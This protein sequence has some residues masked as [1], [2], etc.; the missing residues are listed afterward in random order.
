MPTVFPLTGTLALHGKNLA[1]EVVAL[2]T[3]T[4]LV[5][6]GQ[7]PTRG[8][9]LILQGHAPELSGIDKVL[10]SHDQLFLT[11]KSPGVSLEHFRDPSEDTLAVAGQAPSLLHTSLR[12]PAEV[13]LVLASDA[14]TVSTPD[15]RTTLP[16]TKGLVL[17]GEA[18]ILLVGIG[19]VRA[20]ARSLIA[21]QGQA[22]DANRAEN[23]WSIPPIGT[24]SAEGQAP[25]AFQGSFAYPLTGAVT[26][27]GYSVITEASELFIVP[28][29]S[30]T[31]DPKTN[32]LAPEGLVL[33]ITT[34]APG[35]NTTGFLEPAAASLTLQ[36]FIPLFATVGFAPVNSY[37]ATLTGHAPELVFSSF[38]SEGKGGI[39]S[40]T[41]DRAV[42]P[43]GTPR[44]TIV[45]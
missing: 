36:P 35:R 28:S 38:F 18:P 5:L 4:S 3:E 30:L 7:A 1:V 33:G 45:S 9:G 37:L 26:L 12:T 31:M 20:P 15:A 6:T 8:V 22:P 16:G 14:A 29:G 43:I 44:E 2:V 11:G 40:L 41:T 27:T 17:F 21:F 25:A 19:I 23:V 32:S 39:I 24:L 10:P 34:F 42:V 13:D